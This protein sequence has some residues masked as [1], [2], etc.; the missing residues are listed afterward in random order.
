M[1][2][3]AENQEPWVTCQQQKLQKLKKKTKNNNKAKPKTPN[4]NH[5]NKTESNIH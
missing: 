3:I 1:K 5:P 2:Y 4:K